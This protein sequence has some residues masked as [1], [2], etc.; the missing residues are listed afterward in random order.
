MKYVLVFR[1]E[2]RDDL[3]DAY[4]WYESQQAGLGDEFIDCVDD[5]LNQ[6]GMMPES[7]A[8]VY[9]DIRRAVIKRFPYA[10]YYRVISSRVVV[11][12]IFHGRRDPKSWRLR[13]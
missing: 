1:P 6:I 12:A 10:V 7:Y 8:I 11:T 13:T 3:R 2:V 4:D 9:L 5:L